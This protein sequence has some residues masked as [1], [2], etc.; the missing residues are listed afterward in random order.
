MIVGTVGRADTLRR[1]LDS[2]AGQSEPEFEVIVVDQNDAIDISPITDAYRGDLDIRRVEAPRGLSRARNIGLQHARG[3]VV[4]FPDDDCWYGPHVVARVRRAFSD[5][6]TA[7]LTGRT[8]ASD[9]LDSVSPHRLESGP[10]DRS[11]VFVSGNSNTLFC[12]RRVFETVG[13]FDE[14]LGVGAATPYQSGEET[15]FLLRCLAHRIRV[16]YDRDLV[17]HHC[18]IRNA[19]SAQTRRARVYSQGYGRLLRVHGFGL[20]YLGAGVGRSLGRGILCFV[21]GD[22]DGARSRVHWAQGALVGY[23]SG[24]RSVP[25]H[26]SSEGQ[27]TSGRSPAGQTR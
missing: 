3:I 2:L 21:T 20:T 17:V 12:R 25:D 14:A 15:D 13:G 4:G 19:S 18:H 26:S 9:G 27:L 5:D 24:R 23:L 6:R 8:V 1:L 22:L 10:V 16:D 11:N 7:V